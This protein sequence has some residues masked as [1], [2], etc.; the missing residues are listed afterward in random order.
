MAQCI[1]DCST[2]RIIDL[3]I[4]IYVIVDVLFIIAEI[5][6]IIALPDVVCNVILMSITTILSGHSDKD[7]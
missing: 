6:T 1:G 2:L 7:Q 3:L 5:A 4:L